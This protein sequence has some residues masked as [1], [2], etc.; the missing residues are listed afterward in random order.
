MMMSHIT[1][2]AGFWGLTSALFAA[3]TLAVYI[4]LYVVKERQR[5]AP[6]GLVLTAFGIVGAVGI[7][8]GVGGFVAFLGLGIIDSMN[9]QG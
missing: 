9:H 6:K 3:V 8:L 2:F 1:R 7:G 4:Y 5:R